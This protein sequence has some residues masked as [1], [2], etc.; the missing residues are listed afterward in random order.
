MLNRCPQ[1]KSCGAVLPFWTDDRPPDAI[2]QAHN[3]TLY[4]STQFHQSSFQVEYV[5]YCKEAQ[6]KAKV[7]RCSWL[8]KYDLIYKY[9]DDYQKDDCAQTFCGML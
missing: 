5:N 8:T 6:R 1:F 7:M 2:G 9:T 4:G 3:I